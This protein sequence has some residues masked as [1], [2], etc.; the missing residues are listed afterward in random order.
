MRENTASTGSSKTSQMRNARSRLGKWSPRSS[1]PTVCGLTSTNSASCAR[2]IR[3][4]ARRTPMRLWIGRASPL[5]TGLIQHIVVKTQQLVKS[6]QQDSAT[7]AHSGRAP[8]CG[9]LMPG[10]PSRD[11]DARPR[12]GD[13]HW[14]ARACRTAGSDGRQ[15]AAGAT[16]ICGTTRTVRDYTGGAAAVSSTDRPIGDGDVGTAARSGV[17]IARSTRRAVSVHTRWRRRRRLSTGDGRGGDRSGRSTREQD[18]ASSSSVLRSW[19]WATTIA[20][21]D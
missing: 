16:H 3:R 5:L 19:K 6:L 17:D 7:H 20:G 15:R 12:S 11:V 18:R 2:V 10:Y 14:P 1:A 4:S 21:A 8:R 13:I 9:R